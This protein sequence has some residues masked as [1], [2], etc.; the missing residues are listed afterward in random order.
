MKILLALLFTT[1]AQAEVIDDFNCAQ[2]LKPLA[3]EWKATGA[4]EKH[5][6][7]GLKDHF[8]ASP[9]ET[10]GEWVVAKDLPNGAVISKID[11]SGRVETFLDRVKCEKTSKVYPGEPIRKGLKSD[12]DLKQFV[13]KNNKG[14]IYVWNPQMPLSETGIKEITAAG[15]K[16]NLPVLILLDKNVA[17]KEVAKLKPKLPSGATDRI[18]SLE[19]KMRNVGQHYPALLVFNDKK[20]YPR[21]KYGYEKSDLY[22]SDVLELLRA[23][24]N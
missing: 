2:H 18:D 6:Q 3:K 24:E 5:Y 9:T 11:Q 7:N 20:I 16:L 14:I 23:G 21:I 12:E 15:K 1:L 13:L 22:V 4:W 17:D 19:L 8:F 10:V